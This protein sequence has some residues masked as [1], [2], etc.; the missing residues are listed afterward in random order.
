[1]PGTGRTQRREKR[2]EGP[3][4]TGFAPG[5]L[6][7]ARGRE[8]VV[9]PESKDDLLILR[10]LG[11][12]DDEVAGV[13]LPLEP[14]EAAAFDLPDPARA[15]DFRSSRL[16]RDA[17]RLGFRSS[18]GPFR[19]FARLGCEPRP[20]QLVPLLMA[21]KLEP[22][23]LLIADDVGIGKT[24][25]AALV[26]RELLDRGEVRR[27]AV[28]CPPHLA[29]QWQA[30]LRS[31]FHIEAE[32]VL[33]GT[34]AR[35]ERGSALDQSLFEVHPFTIVSMD[36]IKADRRREDFLRAAP[37]L[38]IVDEAHA[39]AFGASGRGGR[40][41][42]F[43]LLQRLA[44]DP[45][46][47]LIL[48]TA[49]PHSGK[50]EAFRSL[51]A[52]LDPSF[53]ELPADLSGPANEAQRRRL[54][55]HFVQRRRADIRRYLEAETPF[56]AREEKED[57]YRLGP[58][59][60]AL[61]EKVLDHARQTV[62]ESGGTRHRQRVLWWAALALLRALASSPAA[63]A[64]SLR[65][66]A[67][68]AG[69]ASEDEADAAGSRAVLDLEIEDSAEAADRTPGSD[70]TEE[71]ASSAKEKRRLESLAREA[72]A[73]AGKK[74]R[75]LEKAA[76]LVRRLLDDGFRPILF[77]RFIATAEYLAGALRE[78]LGKGVAIEAVTGILP[79]AER[80]ARIEALA[81]GARAAGLKPVLVATD[82]LSEGINL[83]E[84]FDAVVHYDLSWNPTRHEQR[85]G[86]VDRYGQ[87]SARV[88]ILT[89][90]G[91][92]NRIDGI[93]LDVLLRKHRA[94]RSSLG[95]SVPMPL[96]TNAV[97]EALL[98]GLLLRT[99]PEEEARVQ[100]EFDFMPSYLQAQKERLF[101]EWENATER[102]KRSRTVF[103]QESL[104]VAE[105]GRELAE[106]R[107]AIGA[108]VDVER[109]LREA[110]A[111]HGAVV[112]GDGGE[113]ACDLREAPRAL[114]DRL[115]PL[116]R[117]RARFEL[118]VAEGVLHLHRTHPVVEAVSTYV[119]DAAL[120]PE[121]AGAAFRA[122]A[123]RTRAVASRT[124]A[125]LLR[126]RFQIIR[127][128]GDEELSLL[129]EDW[130]LSAFEGAPESAR[131]LEA[132]AAGRLLAAEPSGN[133]APGQASD[134]VSKVIAGFASLRP[135]LEAGARARGEAILS[136]HR[137]VRAEAKLTGWKHRVEPIL[138]PDVL[139]LYVFL[140][141]GS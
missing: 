106:V 18:A 65:S 71:D 118:P 117:F 60:R 80:E 86:R 83:Q 75:K 130:A 121:I 40:H 42:R 122:G 141:A 132:G 127:R 92:D 13:Y 2:E 126:Y 103:A 104:K 128:R 55:A 113:L 39:C 85:D 43:E 97:V 63:A 105:V 88:R 102:E 68:A 5:S 31:K 95:Y 37:E 90:Y 50:E 76:E 81:A 23:R 124:T 29:E 38:L 119:L 27:L 20:Y 44:A 108:G 101:S 111:A 45:E 1:M 58:E 10:P 33:P 67:D 14:V 110:L 98:E 52:F 30:E 120:D 6:V 17:V 136:A 116:E 64:A 61:F 15:A 73:L 4:M 69:T 125:L 91:L 41:Q 135:A 56:P 77:C 59:Y 137:R 36:Y 21:L 87:T 16:L 131:W 9:L 70:A 49:T 138:P 48:V 93:V 53:A 57:H 34:V 100:A 123:V 78:R 114:R 140:P 28:L 115:A 35:L 74:D 107:A 62:R 84:H 54:A 66:R 25:E 99:R 89:Y 82:C 32:L 22:V 46:R 134:F 7:R 26:A 96:D 11:G 109:F 47:H 19:S 133:I 51:L 139:G 3:S 129:A 79:P 112:S 24:I 8:W 72:D 94:I 12:A